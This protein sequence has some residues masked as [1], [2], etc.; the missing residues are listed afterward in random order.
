MQKLFS[1]KQWTGTTN[2]KSNLVGRC[3]SYVDAIICYIL[4]ARETSQ[5]KKVKSAFS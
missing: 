5:S 3:T 1:K 2:K 4:I